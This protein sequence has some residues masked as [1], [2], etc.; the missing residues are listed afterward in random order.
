MEQLEKRLFDLK[1]GILIETKTPKH[2][3]E[4]MKKEIKS[5]E[6]HIEYINKTMKNY[7]K[8]SIKNERLIDRSNGK[9]W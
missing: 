2:I 6:N 3:L 1:F 7:T 5:I 4:S 9:Y 8:R